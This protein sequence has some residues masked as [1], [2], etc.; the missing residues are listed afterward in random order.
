MTSRCVWHY[1]SA[2]SRI[3]FIG[4]EKG[5][6]GKSVVA[7]LLAQYFIDRDIPF[8]GI[9]GDGSNATLLRH[10]GDFSQ[11][12][13]LSVNES[14]DQIL[15]RALGGDR[16][17]VVDLPAQSARAL[18][19]WLGEANVLGLARELGIPITFWHVTDGGFAS[20][21]QLERALDAYGSQAAHVLVKN[22]GRAKD[23]SQLD[24]SA[25]HGKLSALSGKTV[26]LPALD[27]SAMFKIDGSGLSFWAASQGDTLKPLEKERVKLWLSKA[28]AQL[29][30]LGEAI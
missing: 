27:E 6:V 30:A 14:A 28:Y 19:S 9:D 2:V 10:Y 4:G 22:L 16:R 12:V 5:G 25:A 21:G 20:V 11:A 29:E 15:D 1:A 26:E 8:A 24:G 13:D 17:V 7:R 18:S 3:H 23:F